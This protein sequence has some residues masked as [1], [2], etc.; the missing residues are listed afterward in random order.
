M[1]CV[2]DDLTWSIFA[3][4]EPVTPAPNSGNYAAQRGERIGAVL[5]GFPVDRYAVA[6]QRSYYLAND[7]A[8]GML[9]AWRSPVRSGHNSA[10]YRIPPVAAMCQWH[11]FS[12]G[13]DSLRGRDSLKSLT[14]TYGK[15][16][17][18]LQLGSAGLKLKKRLGDV[19]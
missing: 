9:N 19:A 11:A 15:F 12:D 10:C 2:T 17:R 4:R 16:S 6:A 13:I 1:R 14:A 7:V 3:V 18:P 8:K 5:K